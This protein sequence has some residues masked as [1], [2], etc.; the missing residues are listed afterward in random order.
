MAEQ[1]PLLDLSTLIERPLIKIDGERYE[2]LHPD[3]LSVVQSQQVAAWGR[4]I[5]ELNA[6]N[7]LGVKDKTRLSATLGQ[8]ADLIMVGVPE[9]V[10]DKLSDQHR[11]RVAEVFTRL[12]LEDRLKAIT[13]AGA[14]AGI[15][16]TGSKP[17][18]GCSGST[19]NP[20]SGG[21][22]K[23]RSRSSARTPT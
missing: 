7:T 15:K 10:R 9:E 16:P 14:R 8:L 5:D 22:G 23:R 3:E 11:L 1:T 13:A 18:P 4:K 2:I 19:D 20:P 12:P 21:S 6:K 17:Q